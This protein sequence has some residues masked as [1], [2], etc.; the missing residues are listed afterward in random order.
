MGLAR[1][2]HALEL[3]KLRLFKAWWDLVGRR[4]V[5]LILI[6]NKLASQAGLGLQR[7]LAQAIGFLSFLSSTLDGAPVMQATY[8]G[9]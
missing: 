6:R 8:C 9:F 3:S 4:T 7:R 5:N 1:I 2:I